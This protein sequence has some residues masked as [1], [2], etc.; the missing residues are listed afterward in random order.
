VLD[1]CIKMGMKRNGREVESYSIVMCEEKRGGVPVTVCG[2]YLVS[3]A[4][5]SLAFHVS[6]ALRFQCIDDPSLLSNSKFDTSMVPVRRWK[7][8]FPSSQTMIL[9]F[10]MLVRCRSE[11]QRCVLL[12][13][14]CIFS[15]LITSIAVCTA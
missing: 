3:Q 14:S 12:L 8:L 9:E 2:A 6:V 1:V 13:F 4:F 5:K 10:G 15:M 7:L 11:V